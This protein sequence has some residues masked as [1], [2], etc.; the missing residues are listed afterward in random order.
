MSSVGTLGSSVTSQ[1]HIILRVMGMK[2]DLT[3]L[4]S[5][6]LSLLERSH[7]NGISIW[8]QFYSHIGFHARIPPKFH[9]FFLVYERQAKLP[10]EFVMNL[11]KVHVD[12]RDEGGSM[13]EFSA[14]AYPEE[15]CCAEE[16]P[17]K[18][19]GCTRSSKKYYDAKHK[20]NKGKFKVGVL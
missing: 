5:D 14:H 8:M 20:Q 9:P 13:P 16:S 1:V 18:H 17:E 11:E 19:K 4:Y 7:L 2:N 10:I 3:R 12:I 6:N 15:D